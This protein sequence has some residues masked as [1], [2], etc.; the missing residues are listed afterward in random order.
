V[1]GAHVDVDNR[2]DAPQLRPAIEL[3]S[4]HAGYGT[5]DILRGVNISVASGTV[6][7]LLGANGAGK[8][9]V[10]RTIS[11]LLRPTH[12]QVRLDGICVNGT[13]AQRRAQRGLLHITEGRG[14]YRGLTVKDN[15]RMQAPRGGDREALERAIDAFPALGKRLKQQAGTMSGGEQQML[16]LAAAHVRRAKVLIVDE[17]SL[18]LAPII[19]DQVFEYLG[20]VANSGTSLLVVDQYAHRVLSLA[21]TAYVLRRGEI[22]FAGA[23]NE[24][25]QSDVFD[26]YLGTEAG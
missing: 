1:I 8:S 15:I 21:T 14:V 5:G 9:T 13:T 22:V 3:K 16:A 24:L 17:P 2:P 25:E 7:A 18:G 23:A 6:T 12:G 4:V 20:R 19:V 11:G 10:L 26:H